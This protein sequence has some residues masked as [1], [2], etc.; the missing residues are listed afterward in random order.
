MDIL[1]N[2]FRNFLVPISVIFGVFTSV[3]LHAQE[4]PDRPVMNKPPNPM[5]LPNQSGV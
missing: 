1:I 3:G 4:P 5:M 2:S